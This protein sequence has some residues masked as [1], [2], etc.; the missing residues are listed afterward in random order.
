MTTFLIVRHASC[1]PV[2]RSLAGRAPGVALNAAGRGEAARLA[3]RLARRQVSAL[4]SSPVQRAL[5]TAA[6]LADV[7]QLPARECEALTEIDF[8]D[9]TGRTLD[10]LAP[11]PAWQRFNSFRSG[12]RAAGGELMLEAQ[13]RA[14]AAVQRLRDEH[15]GEVV[16][17]VGHADVLKA[18][19]GYYV[20]VPIDLCHRLELAPAS[21]SV[22]E[23]TEY[24]ARLLGLN[25]VGPPPR[26]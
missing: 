17:L 20:G 16:A 15:P 22:L 4:Y 7:W 11:E 19:I 12:T 1:D 23:V 13:A 24:G 6:W 26:G 8:G 9:W 25:D 2:G 14:V 18:L 10:A 5:E 3:H 21:L